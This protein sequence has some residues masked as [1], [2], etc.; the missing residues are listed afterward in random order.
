MHYVHE[1]DSLRRGV[2][3][4][5]PCDTHNAFIPNNLPLN[6]TSHVPP[7]QQRRLVLHVD[8]ECF[9]F[10]LRATVTRHVPPLAALE[11]APAIAAFAA[12][13]HARECAA[14]VVVSIVMVITAAIPATPISAACMLLPAL[15]TTCLLLLLR[16]QQLFNALRN[17]LLCVV[18]V[19][20]LRH[21]ESSDNLFNRRCVEVGEHLDRHGHLLETLGDDAEDLLHDAVVLQRLAHLSKACD[22]AVDP[23]REVADALTIAEADVLV[24]FP[25]ALHARGLHPVIVDP[26][27]PHRLPRFFRRLLHGEPRLHLRRHC[28]QDGGHCPPILGTLLAYGLHRVPS[29]I[30]SSETCITNAHSW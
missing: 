17:S 26:H 15:S 9:L 3:T 30:A 11:A 21:T 18:V 13:A 10:L 27:R 7:L 19:C 1:L 20:V 16:E 6:A 12:P 14:G 22:E 23:Q 2:H 5:T 8:K 4:P 29:S 24:L 25:Q 28:A